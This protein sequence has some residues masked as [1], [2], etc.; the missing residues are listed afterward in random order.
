MKLIGRPLRVFTCV[1]G[2]KHVDWF[3]NGTIK[4]L[5]WPKNKEAL[6][7]STWTIVTFEESKTRIEE[8]VSAA[9]PNVLVKVKTVPEQ[10]Q[11]SMGVVSSK[12][13]DAS[14]LILM[15][16][17]A[18]IKEC[19]DS[20]SRMLLA[21]PDTIFGEGTIPNLLKLGAQDGTCVAVAH[22]RVLPDIL[23]F[24]GDEP[25]SNSQLVSLAFGSYLH[26]SWAAA[27]S[28]APMQNSLVGGVSWERLTKV[29]EHKDLFAVHHRL[30]TV[31]LSN[32]LPEDYAF[33]LNQPSL[34]SYDHVWPG[35]RLIRQERQ[36]TVGSSDACFIVEMTEFDKNIP[37]WNEQMQAV[38][39]QTPDA[40]YRDNLHNCINRLFVTV[41]R[42]E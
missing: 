40:F 10:V 8:L 28:G 12:Q 29:N 14:V 39:D 38:I 36:R 18:E 25:V 35:E 20:G 34:G 4:S 7:G 3:L 30:P 19:V 11:L 15:H 2:S 37:P 13:L 1:W 26:Q 5:S 22:P 42:G 21:P 23:D 32:W 27:E 17:Q 41:F 16:L 31:Y 6:D 33:F 24:I 9:F